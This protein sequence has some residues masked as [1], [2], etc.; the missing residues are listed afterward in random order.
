MAN[1]VLQG[2][3]VSGIVSVVPAKTRR[4]E[5][6]TYFDLETAKKVSENVGVS[7]RHID[8]SLCTSDLC[9][10]AAERL[11]VQLNW[12]REEIRALIF[13]TQTPDY[14]LPATSHVLHQRLGLPSTCCVFDVNLG[15]SGYVYGLWLA[16]SS[17]KTLGGKVLLL[18]GDIS[19]RITSPLD[20]S[21]V[22]LF[23]DAGT[24]TGLD[25]DRK[26]VV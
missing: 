11:L 17:V 21:V 20:Q 10:V 14:F 13:V 12:N 23:G 5:D 2:V 22:F 9:A 16:A 15:C 25:L 26:S 18:V 4:P 24:A 7:I 1:C 19:S 3:Q 8:P 6:E